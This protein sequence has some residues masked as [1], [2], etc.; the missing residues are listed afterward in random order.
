VEVVVT[1][2]DEGTSVKPNGNTVAGPLITSADP[3][4]TDVLLAGFEVGEED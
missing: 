4:V 3:T 2:G 1:V